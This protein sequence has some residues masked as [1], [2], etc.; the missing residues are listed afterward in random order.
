[1]TAAHIWEPAAWLQVSGPDAFNFLQ[2]QFTNDLRLLEKQPAVY[3]LWLNEKGKVQGDSFVLRGEGGAFWVGSYFSPA[4][5]LCERLKA[6]VIADDVTIE[7]CTAGCRGVT[8]IGTVASEMAE[9]FGGALRFPGRRA[10]VPCME[11]MFAT[12]TQPAVEARMAELNLLPLPDSDM[13][14]FRIK[15]SITA[16]PRDI[17]PD[18]LPNEGGL[19]AVAISYTKGC[20]LGQEVMA[21]LKSMGQVR[22]Q[23][24]RVTG[25]G[26]PP[27][28]PAT[29]Y[30]GPKRMGELRSAAPDHEGFVGFALL[31]LLG[32]DQC[33]GLSYASQG[34]PAV[35]LVEIKTTRPPW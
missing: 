21:R 27:A 17:G 7:D 8:L 28:L 18:D 32:L 34:E 35:Q 29:L 26:A 33:P 25:A 16:V 12:E 15:A 14:L 20:Y 3:G 10:T 19:D 11:L 31:S 5:T 2:G 30:N 24:L 13:E 23:L 9:K 22:R 4:A 6:F 1:M